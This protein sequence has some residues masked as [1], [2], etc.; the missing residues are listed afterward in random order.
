MAENV[1][2]LIFLQGR[3]I[4]AV[5]LRLRASNPSSNEWN[6]SCSAHRG[7]TAEEKPQAVRPNHFPQMPV[8]DI[9]EVSRFRG[10]PNF[11]ALV[12]PTKTLLS[13]NKKLILFRCPFPIS[14][15]VNHSLCK[16]AMIC[17]SSSKVGWLLIFT[18]YATFPWPLQLC[19]I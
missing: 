18:L 7:R 17:V 19:K 16:P 8:N 14:M 5:Q 9:L 12:A 15:K 3:R 11:D 13:I 6:P 1:I 2:S 4:N 10:W